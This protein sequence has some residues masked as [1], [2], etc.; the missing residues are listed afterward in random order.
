MDLG[1][2]FALFRNKVGLTQKEASE[3]IGIKPYQLGNYEIN[4][5]E[6]S[7]ETLKKMSHLYNVSIDR[8][9]GNQMKSTV[10]IATEQS[11]KMDLDEIKIALEELLKKINGKL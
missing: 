1:K 9:V 4:R 3:R 8:L 7:I 10:P 2:R 6:P 11:E 5:S